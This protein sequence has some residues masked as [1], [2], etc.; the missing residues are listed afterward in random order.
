M[1]GS[2]VAFADTFSPRPKSLL[3]HTREAAA[4]RYRRQVRLIPVVRSG[5][6]PG[7]GDVPYGRPRGRT[8]V[9]K[10]RLISM[11]RRELAQLSLADGGAD[12]LDEDQVDPWEPELGSVC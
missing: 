12:G 2:P 8:A 5:Q 4:G 3:Q 7:I 10:H 1:S 11:A 9:A 6:Q